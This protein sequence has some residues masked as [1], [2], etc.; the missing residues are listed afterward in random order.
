[1]TI[2]APPQ[3]RGPGATIFFMDLIR[4]VASQLVVVGHSINVYLPGLYMIPA[5]DS[6][7]QA[8]PGGIYVQNLAVLIF[9]YVSGYLITAT[10]LRKSRDPSWRLRHFLADRAARIFTPLVPLLLILLVTD[11][12]VFGEHV[13]TQYAVIDAGLGDFVRNLTMLFSNPWLDKIGELTGQTWLY[14]TA[15]GSADQLWTIVIEWWIYVLFGLAAFALIRRRGNA[16]VWGAFFLFALAV[17]L[18]AMIHFSG[19]VVAWIVGM[20]MRLAHDRLRQLRPALLA[21][22]AGVSFAI[23]APR[24]SLTEFNFYDPLTAALL[25]VALFAFM[26]FRESGRARVRPLVD[27]LVTGMSN[28]SYSL[29]LV[30]L[31]LILYVAEWLPGMIGRPWALVAML[32]VCNAG[33]TL[34][35]FLFE[36][37]YP[38]VRRWL[39]PYLNR[40][41]VGVPAEAKR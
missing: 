1:M 27:A 2:E 22:L 19:L 11:N 8:R 15:F 12:L 36:R 26:T 31:T 18:A 17:P 9:F 40:G 7:L 28:I 34:F 4:G 29:Y 38:R 5:T 33:A 6:G 41:G 13:A 24:W 39:E 14:G 23:A 3:Q 37:H 32:V 16:L 21:A 25:G 10:F 30:H 35:Y 20:A